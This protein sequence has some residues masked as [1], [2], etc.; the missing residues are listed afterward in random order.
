MGESI[1]SNFKDL[2]LFEYQLTPRM[3]K[4]YNFERLVSKELKGF[5]F[6]WGLLRGLGYG[7]GTDFWHRKYPIQIEAKF[8][9]AYIYPSWIKRD[10]IDRFDNVKYKIVVTN[11]GIKLGERAKELLKQHNIIH[12]FLDQL[13]ALVQWLIF[14]MKGV[15]SYRTNM[16]SSTK[17][18]CTRKIE[19]R[20][21]RRITYKNK[22]I[23]H[24][25]KNDFLQSTLGSCADDH[26]PLLAYILGISNLS[27][28]IKHTCLNDLGLTIRRIY[29]FMPLNMRLKD[30]CTSLVPIHWLTTFAFS[31]FRLQFH[32]PLPLPF[33]YSIETLPETLNDIAYPY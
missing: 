9:H 15:T 30:I 17:D 25:Y 29:S 1:L 26:L 14:L 18:Y 5:D 7:E 32:E 3:Q 33:V 27:H 24:R 13:R 10:W 22:R 2:K 19:N 16:Y 23:R 6:E 12:V 28:T 4:G 11:R 31:L 21:Y 20:T 8:S